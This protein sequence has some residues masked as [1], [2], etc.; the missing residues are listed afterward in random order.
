MPKNEY[1]EKLDRNG[2]APSIM[3][4]HGDGWCYLC[5]EDVDTTERH[6][7]FFGTGGSR[8]KCKELGLWVNLC[9]T[10]HRNGERAVHTNAEVCQQVK[11]DAQR[12]AMERYGWSEETFRSYFWK[13][14]L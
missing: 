14:Y 5:H 11:Q 1:G 13:S 8:Q 12:A 9:P 6:E 3:E 2:Y 10:C 4:G 7:V